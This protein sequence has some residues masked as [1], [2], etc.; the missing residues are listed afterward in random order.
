MYIYSV[1]LDEKVKRGTLDY[2]KSF[3]STEL[4]SG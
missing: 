3:F 2:G 1:F 4:H